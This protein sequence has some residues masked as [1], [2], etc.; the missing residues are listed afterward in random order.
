MRFLK[1]ES[2]FRTK[3]AYQNILLSMAGYASGKA[4]GTSWDDVMKQ[5][6]FNPLKM[7]S[8]VTTLQ[9]FLKNPNHASNHYIIN[10][11]AYYMDPI[12][13]DAMGPAATI[14]SSI[15]DLGNWLLFQ[16]NRGKFN[17]QQIISYPF[18][19]ETYKPHTMIKQEPNYN[20]AYGLGWGIEWGPGMKVIS[21]SGSTRYSTSNTFLFPLYD[22]GIIVVANE[23]SKGNEFGNLLGRALYQLYKKNALPGKQ[24]LS[25]T[26]TS[27]IHD[28]GFTEPEY[29]KL[30]DKIVSADPLPHPIENY[31]GNY[32]SDYWG[33]LKITKKDDS[34]LLAYTGE[35]PNPTT[36][37]HWT[38]NTFKDEYYQTEVKFSDFV[39]N[40]PQ[41]LDG[42]R[43]EIYGAN[44]TFTRV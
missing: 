33:N 20:G 31:A 27:I 21:H 40:K 5:E 2:E 38:G 36:L 8:S 16:V 12:N 7:D 28:D 44:G 29:D 11:K 35:N 32:Y 26:L 4:V 9:D 42:K 6:I 41:K 1:P 39:G 43:W 34:S 14:S 30:P 37:K 23:G 22:L 17:G 18:L 13:L 25:N 19:A 24:A 10:G 3:F 15:K